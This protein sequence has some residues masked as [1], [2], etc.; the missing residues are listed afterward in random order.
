MTKQESQWRVNG[1]NIS[2]PA[3]KKILY[4]QNIGLF[5]SVRSRDPF[6]AGLWVYWETLELP[7]GRHEPEPH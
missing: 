6:K 7:G 1:L 5:S 4:I 3:T 2:L